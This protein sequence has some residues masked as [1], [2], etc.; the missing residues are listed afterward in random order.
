MFGGLCSLTK[1]DRAQRNWF[2]HFPPP[3]FLLAK[4][5]FLVFSRFLQSV[6]TGRVSTW[7]GHFC[8]I[9]LLMAF[10]AVGL[11]G[12]CMAA[13][14]VPGAEGQ[15]WLW[16]LQTWY[17]PLKGIR[18]KQYHLLATVTVSALGQI[19]FHSDVWELVPRN[20]FEPGFL[21]HPALPWAAWDPFHKFLF[22]LNWPEY[23]FLAYN[24]ELWP[25]YSLWKSND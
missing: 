12:F 6:W 2:S 22:Q 17:S 3:L 10:V 4:W 13:R 25:K 1:V 24:Y 11:W 14:P 9:P 5:H 21:A 19:P 15:G 20:N 8:T 18:K 7:E 16:H 23:A